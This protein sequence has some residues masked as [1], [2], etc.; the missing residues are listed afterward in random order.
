MRPRDA[1]RSLKAITCVNNTQNSQPIIAS[2]STKVQR[3][4]SFCGSVVAAARSSSSAQGATGGTST[5][6]TRAVLQRVGGNCQR[7][8]SGTAE[9][10][11]AL[12]ITAMLSGAGARVD[13]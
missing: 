3:D 1:T 8:A 2:A 6:P 13:A 12:P 11:R 9:A 7:R 10:P 4:V 5:A